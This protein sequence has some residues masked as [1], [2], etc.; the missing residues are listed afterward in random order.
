MLSALGTVVMALVVP[1]AAAAVLAAEWFE[2]CEQ[3]ASTAVR[4]IA[5]AV[6]ATAVDRPVFLMR[7]IGNSPVP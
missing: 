1:L 2:S 7:V 6:A 3:P 4:P 5:A